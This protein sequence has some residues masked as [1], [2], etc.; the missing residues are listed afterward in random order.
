MQNPIF[1]L[2][3]TFPQNNNN[4]NM[5]QSSQMNPNFNPSNNGTG[6]M[7]NNMN[8]MNTMNFL[9]NMNSP[10]NNSVQNLS[11]SQMSHVSNPMNNPMANPMN[12]PMMNP[13]NNPMM[14]QM[15]MNNMNNMNN[16]ANMAQMSLHLQNQYQNQIQDM[17]SNMNQ[18]NQ[19]SGLQTPLKNNITVVFRV[20]DN[21]SA[22]PLKIQCTSSDRISDLIE[23]YRNKSQD[24][25]PTKKFIFNARELDS[26][27]T[28]GEAGL[29]EG[30][31]IFVV[32]TKGIK[33]A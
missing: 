32:K 21:I 11:N 16:M 28:V 3:G 26:N 9:D 4:N 25:D 1:N 31:N 29:Y 33:G 13:M 22:D 19:N 15:M 27:L 17:N 23:R 8:S 14:N 6:M 10:L 5:A 12:N 7:N 20:G 2:M 24:N 30:S 18:D